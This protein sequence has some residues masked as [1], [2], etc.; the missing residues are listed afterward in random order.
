MALY[1]EPISV[2]E[3]RVVRKR[4]QRGVTLVGYKQSHSADLFL[5]SAINRMLSAINRIKVFFFVEYVYFCMAVYKK[6]NL[7]ASLS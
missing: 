6:G 5:L 1:R 7:R 3:I 2:A 4:C